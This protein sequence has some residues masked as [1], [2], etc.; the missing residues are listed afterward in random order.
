MF[1]EIYIID[2]ES[3]LV[4]MLREKFQKDKTFRFKNIKPENIDIALKNIPDL[5]VINEKSI[6][7]NVLELCQKIR[8]NEDNSI[9]PV[10]V[11]L[12]DDSQE[13]KLDIMKNNIE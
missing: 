6:N 13:H 10:L 11:L 12:Q 3:D 7:T 2:C 5:M 1:E 8:E 4:M 9:T